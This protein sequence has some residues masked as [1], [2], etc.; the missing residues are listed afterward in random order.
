[1]APAAALAAVRSRRKWPCAQPRVAPTA[2]IASTFLEADVEACE[3]SQASEIPSVFGSVRGQGGTVKGTLADCQRQ[4]MFQDTDMMKEQIKA[5]L[6]KPKY[7]IEENYRS[8][9]L[10]QWLARSYW[11]EQASLLV[12]ASNAIWIA[13]DTDYNHADMLLNANGVFI[14][15]ENAFCAFFS[16]EWLVR[17][18][19]YKSKLAC[20]QDMRF[21]FDTVLFVT[22]LV[23]TWVMPL[24]FV[25]AGFNTAELIGQSSLVKVVRIF[26]LARVARMGRLLRAAPELMVL[27]K[28]MVAA[29]RSVFFTLML[30]TA[31]IYVFAIVFVH[32][33]AGTAFG[34][35]YFRTV[36]ESMLTLLL[37]GTYLDEVTELVKDMRQES[38]FLVIVFLAF[39]LLA[40]QTLMNML[41]GVLCEVVSVVASTEKEERTMN[42]VM[43]KLGGILQKWSG[44]NGVAISKAEFLM[45]LHDTEAATAL[46]EVGVDAVGLVD[47][48]DIIFEGEDDGEQAQLSFQNIMDIVF[49]FRGSNTATV[50]DLV[51]VQRSVR[52][53][54]DSVGGMIAGLESRLLRN[55]LFSLED[56]PPRLEKLVSAASLASGSTAASPSNGDGAAELS[57]LCWQ[58]ELLKCGKFQDIEVVKCG[59]LEDMQG[60][61]TEVQAG[62]KAA[63]QKNTVECLQSFSWM[64][65]N[66]EKS[67]AN[68]QELTSQMAALKAENQQFRSR[69]L[70]SEACPVTPSKDVKEQVAGNAEPLVAR[71]GEI[72][73]GDSKLPNQPH[74]EAA[75][76]S[77][78]EEAAVSAEMPSQLERQ[79]S[80]EGRTSRGGRLNLVEDALE[81]CLGPTFGAPHGSSR[82]RRQ[83]G[84][85]SSAADKAASE[86]PPPRASLRASGSAQTPSLSS[87]T[88]AQT[89]PV[90]SP[91][92]RVLLQPLF[93]SA[94]RSV[95]RTQSPENSTPSSPSPA[96]NCN[97]NPLPSLLLQPIVQTSNSLGEGARPENVVGTLKEHGS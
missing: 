55:G 11:F 20:C 62:F 49:Q 37:R 9:G 91:S 92:R 22:T 45:M 63:M 32:L 48:V 80:G 79:T 19:A 43:A 86:S 44:S 72:E 64:S 36:A 95:S 2:P 82:A 26:R 3:R 97:P 5:N 29:A 16:F 57:S 85:A 13:V 68:Q 81:F 40:A 7:C 27:M 14:F 74:A 35:K 89:E 61:I 31:A 17:F 56:S 69:M 53:A 87:P 18:L 21:M 23:E 25:L 10:A 6:Y 83:R 15:F 24:V 4:S 50:K 88:L 1:M 76:Q 77:A 71:L 54:I 51:E 94:S 28:G 60:I 73:Q 70:I 75:L 33:T 47:F 90:S 38:V 34:D 84:A 12:I 58:S 42:F 93:R 59:K 39:V 52:S 30:M 66:L 67:M 8:S 46:H 65:Q 78:R 96:G 41:I